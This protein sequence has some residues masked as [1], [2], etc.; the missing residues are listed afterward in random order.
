MLFSVSVS[1]SDRGSPLNYLMN[2]PMGLEVSFGVVQSLLEKVRDN[3]IHT[4]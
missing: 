3:L 4:Y 2:P 1:E